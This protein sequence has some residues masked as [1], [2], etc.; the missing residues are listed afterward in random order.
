ML[1]MLKVGKSIKTDRKSWFGFMGTLEFHQHG[2]K[3]THGLQ[4]VCE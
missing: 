1:N 3:K 4:S 2:I